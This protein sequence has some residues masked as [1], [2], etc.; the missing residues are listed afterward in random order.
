MC[1]GEEGV[2]TEDMEA[3]KRSRA[4]YLHLCPGLLGS[5]LNPIFPV[6]PRLKK[7][8]LPRASAAVSQGFIVNEKVW[9]EPPRSPQ[10]FC[11]GVAEMSLPHLATNN[12]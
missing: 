8:E 5:F 6:R 9:G 11:V 1:A 4:S 2:A 12:L 3:V 7:A 10:T